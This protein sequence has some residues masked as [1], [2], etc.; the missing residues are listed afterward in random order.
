MTWKYEFDNTLGI[1]EVTYTG[2]VSGKDIHDLTSELLVLEKEKGKIGFLVD[3][4]QMDYSGSLS[5]LYELPAT[6]YVK[7]E[8]DRFNPL[9][10]ILSASPKEKKAAE[11][12]EMVCQNRGWKAKTFEDR[13]DAIKWLTHELT[14]LK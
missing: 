8:A 5:D 10:V 9:A 12:Y 13:Q 6:Q 14:G 2:T 4:T 11:F 3:T 7:E 1:V